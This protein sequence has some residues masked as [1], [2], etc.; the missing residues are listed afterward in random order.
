V[1]VEARRVFRLSLTVASSLAVG[2]GIGLDLPFIAPIFALMLTAA[3]GPPMGA[4]SLLGLILVV[5]LT[6]GMGLLLIPMLLNYRTT[7]VLLVAVGIFFSSY[8]TVNLGKGLVGA[9]LTVGITMISAAG[10]LS[11]QLATTVIEALV[12]GVGI[13]VVCHRCVY[14]LFPEVDPNPAP[15]AAPPTPEQNGWIAVRTTLVVLPAYL[16]T[17]TNPS[18]YLPIAMKAVALG[19]QASEVHARD[20]ARE[21][22]GST[23]LGG[24]LAI[25][26][27][28]A[29]GVA[30]NL[31]MF[32]LWMLL[33]GVILTA[34]FY[35]VTPSRHPPSFW[36]NVLVTMLILLGSA[37]QDTSSGSDVYEAFATRMTLFVAVTV[38]ALAAVV[39][40]ER[41]RTR[42]TRR[43][44]PA[45]PRP[46]QQ[47]VGQQTTA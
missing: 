21:L 43:P 14:P 35:Q 12:F 39:I 2:Y 37:V 25:V 26:F 8:L 34:R 29:L 18:A 46:D 10:T 1:D 15:A 23:F 45:E 3:P 4:K 31:W 7:A 24:I 41:L 30:T 32:F 6:L 28:A 42:K 5:V 47:N 20:A 40:L 22:L 17:L 19:Q 16:L 36:Q 44:Y 13:A 11:Y 38:Y 33:F 9:L 27:W